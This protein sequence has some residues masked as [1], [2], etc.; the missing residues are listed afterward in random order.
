VYIPAHC[1]HV[2]LKRV[3]RALPL[4]RLARRLASEPAFFSTEFVVA[5]TEGLGRACVLRLVREPGGE[6]A[7]RPVRAVEPVSGWGETAVVEA[8][9]DVDDGWEVLRA[10]RGAGAEVAVVLGLVGHA[11][12]A[13]LR[14]RLRA[15]HVYDVVPPDDDRLLL[16]VRE[17][18]GVLPVPFELHLRDLAEEARGSP[19]GTVVLPCSVG[20]EKL[21]LPGKRV[22][23]FDRLDRRS[24]R[25]LPPGG[26]LA[27]GC[28]LGRDILSSLGAR[29]VRCET[30]CPHEWLRRPAGPFLTRCCRT[31]RT[32]PVVIDG[33]RGHVLHW[34][35]GRA[36]FL[37]AAL[38]LDP[39]SY[40]GEA[41]TEG[42]GPG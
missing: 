18:R 37:R 21:D 17:A 30:I 8:P 27:F 23:F 38:S 10:A 19:E 35:A 15:V 32:G 24:A 12:F 36:E 28:E 31:K 26:T 33:V 14:A 11:T 13:D 22:L 20:A 16:H 42:E 25:R 5:A 2:A 6:G 7:L 34:G 41:A 40:L 1:K 3:S 39:P 4:E 9:V 29:G